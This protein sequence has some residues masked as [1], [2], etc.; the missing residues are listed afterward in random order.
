M[1]SITTIVRGRPRL[2]IGLAAGLLAEAVLIAVPSPLTGLQRGILS[3]DIGC[4][5]FLVSCAWM[6]S[7]E[8]MARMSAD[9]KA[10]QEGEWTIFALTVGAT[11]ASFAAII[12]EFSMSKDV[13]ASIR[14]AHVALVA[15]TLLLS[16][17]MTHTLFALRYAH[18]YY[19]WDDEMGAVEKG[20]EFPGDEPPDYWDFFYFA[21]VLGMTFQVSDVQIKSRKLRRVATLHGL[22]G[23]LFNTVILALSVNIGAGLLS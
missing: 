7:T 12:G 5:V 23:F 6:F 20:L 21:L 16:W 2:F 1:T 10:Q 17:L 19:S 18:E 9:A 15:V 13:A 22:L 8:R 14:N 3:W 4:I 11:F